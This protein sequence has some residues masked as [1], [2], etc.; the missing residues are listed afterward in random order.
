[1]A[2]INSLSSS[3]QVVHLQLLHV[4]LFLHWV[5]VEAA[6][7]SRIGA[8]AAPPPVKPLQRSAEVTWVEGDLSPFVLFPSMTPG[9]NVRVPCV[10]LPLGWGARP[11]RASELA[12]I[13]DVPLLFQEW[14]R[15]NDSAYL[16]TQL[17]SSVPG[18]TLLLGGDVLL[19]N[20]FWGGFNAM[21]DMVDAADI[22][23]LPVDLSLAVK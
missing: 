9:V 3:R 14:C 12:T 19:T 18:K 17:L 10:F 20:Y 15:D 8:R 22:K 21:E 2:D 7:D 6:L 23:L 16:L 13:W 4:A 1:M 11:L 5:P